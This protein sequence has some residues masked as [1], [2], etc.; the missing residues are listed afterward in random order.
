MEIQTPTRMVTITV[1]F[2]PR[3]REFFGM[4]CD[5][6]GEPLYQSAPKA[7]VEQIAT[8]ITER[9]EIAVPDPVLQAVLQD[10]NDFQAGCPNVGRRIANY[11][12]AGIL[13]NSA[14]F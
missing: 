9:L 10:A 7:S 11:C 14:T 12:A 3:Q 1:G 4:A 13:L 2:D 5:E 8:D 6:E